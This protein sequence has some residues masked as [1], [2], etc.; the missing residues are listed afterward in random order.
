MRK[1]SDKIRPIGAPSVLRNLAERTACALSSAELAEAAGPRQYGVGRKA[2]LEEAIH[3]ARAL[4]AARP[5]L[6]WLSLDSRNAFNALW[7]RRVLTAVAARIP[8]LAAYAGFTLGRGSRY[9][10]QTASGNLAG[11]TQPRWDWEENGR[12]FLGAGHGLAEIPLPRPLSTPRTSTA[13]SSRRGAKI[14]EM[15][16]NPLERSSVALGSEAP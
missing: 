12:G 10:F 11:S 6:V 3:T 14:T 7:R 13:A 5:K 8:V 9:W 15:L 4:A 2:G 16:I 1:G